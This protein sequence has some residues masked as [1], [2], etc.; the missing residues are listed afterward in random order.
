M[1]I[2]W[3]YIKI[4]SIAVSIVFLYSFTNTRNHRRNVIKTEIEF[5]NKEPLY[6]AHSAVNK[7]LIQNKATVMNLPKEKLAL[8]SIEKALNANEMIE[9]AQVYLTINGVLTAEIIQKTPIARIAADDAYYVDLKGKTM[10]LSPIFSA[11]VPLVTGVTAKNQ[12]NAIYS[13]AKYIYEDHFLKTYIIG[14]HQEHKSLTLKSRVDH[15][16]IKIGMAKNLDRKFKK[17]KAFYQKALKDNTL[18]NYSIVNLE[19]NNQIVC[20]KN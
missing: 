20:T 16:T 5:V 14:I 2:N 9:E 10:P 18:D 15:F 11:R 12:L 4:F 1:N 7:L 6:I 17:F 8:N 13:V 19:F 3:N